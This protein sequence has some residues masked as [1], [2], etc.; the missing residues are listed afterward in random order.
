MKEILKQQFQASYVRE[1]FEK[2]V[3]RPIFQGKVNEY[4][5]LD[6]KTTFSVPLTDGEKTIAKSIN[7]YGHIVTADDR[8]IE[9]Y[10]VVLKDDKVVERNK[11]SIGALVKKQII[12]NN[13]VFINFTYENP[14]DKN[15]RFSFIAF[16]SVFEDGD[17]KTIETNPKRYTYI[18]GESD[19]TYKTAVD[20]FSKL[21]D[22]LE[23]KIGKIKDAFGVEAMSKAFF[24]EY[25]DTHYKNFVNH[26]IHSN[27]KKSAFDGD[28]KAIR[29]FIKK[30]LGRIVFLYF[31]QKK[32][33]LGATTLD[34]NDGDKNFISNFFKEAKQGMDFYSMWLSKL[35][36]DTLNEKRKDDNFTMPDDSVVKIPYLNGGLF[37]K[38]TDK[39]DFITFEPELFAS[40][41][42]F[43]DQYNFTV[44]EDSPD[45]HT[46]AVDPEMLGHIF[47]N[48]LEH[49]PKTGAFYTP[50]QIVQY[51]T[52]E[53][54]IEYLATYLPNKKNEI[55][56]FIK[57]QIV[58]LNDIE[59]KEIDNLIDKVKICD[60]AI[61]SGA[62]P[63][64][65]LQ[66]IFSLKEQIAYKFGFKVWRPALVKENIIQNSIYGVDIEKGAVD[67]ARLR[68]W[69]SLI[70][71][72]D[73]PKALPNLDYKIVIGNSLVSKFEEE[74]IEIDWNIKEGAQNNLFG[75]SLEE[76]KQKLLTEVSEKQ[77]LFFHTESKDKKKLTSEIRIT[78]IKLLSKQLELMIETKG[79]KE[80]RGKILNKKQ[81]E[82]KLE[83]ES[84]KN[85]L[86]DL[87]RL[88]KNTELPFNHFDWKLDFPEIL[89]PI[90]SENEIGFD[91]VIGNPPYIKEYTNKDAF[92]GFRKSD[93]YQGKMD[94]WYGFSCMMIDNLKD[95]GIQSFI[96]QNNWITSAGASKLRFKILTDTEIKSFVDFGNYKVF[97]SAGIQ[98]MI[99]VV[100][101]KKYETPY[102][103]KYSVLL[104]DKI[105]QSK[106]NDFLN[107]NLHNESAQKYIFEVTNDMISDKSFTFNTN[108][109]EVLLNYIFN[110]ANYFFSE[111]D[112]A[113]GIVPNPD[114]VNNRNIEK[115]PLELIKKFDIK[116]NDGVFVVKRDTFKDIPV[117]EKKYIKP[118]FEPREVSRYKFLNDYE[119]EL[120]YIN[121]SNYKN[122][123]PHLMEHLKKYRSIMDDRRENL[124]GRLDYYHLHWSR[125]ENY[126]KS[127][128]KILA[129]RKCAVP[130]FIYTEEPAYVMMSFNI[131]KNDKLNMKFLT[132]LLN[133]NLIAFWLKN[134]GSMQ[135]SNFQ[136]DKAPLLKIPLFIPNDVTKFT[137]LVDYLLYLNNPN[138]EQLISHTDNKR[139]ASHIEDILNAMINELYFEKHMKDNEL[140]VLDYLKPQSIEDLSDSEQ[141]AIVRN[142]YL[143]YQEPQN[144][145]RQA[146]MLVDTR[147]K[148]ILVKINKNSY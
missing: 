80:D 70:V 53:S 56:L 40:L 93:Y 108:D 117:N 83:T 39:T 28:E 146:I 41:F 11:V 139:V 82:A 103:L 46:V 38:D 125:D 99:Y 143:W 31:L 2:N 30:L 110:K 14:E 145:I 6:N 34:Y 58:E 17:I 43:F 100:Q 144:L 118:L 5:I 36:F 71:D 51:M 54:L 49:N 33:W 23:I 138:N 7:K 76:D 147:S 95:N 61:G 141:A 67:I 92:D 22:E 126:F 29:D 131:I 74:I 133:S 45:D 50:K 37:E 85:T 27:F 10:E 122:D 77:K 94:L 73:L 3:L 81:L 148:D 111:K 136:L 65:L 120:I 52:Q 119:S 90:V 104:D 129:V 113:Q 88:E 42:D 137:I 140:D 8:K 75:S 20:C 102:S 96:A 106:L 66:E 127:G 101:K 105:P 98:T 26:L 114:V 132:S 68:F 84:W 44:Y 121:K 60:P 1:A 134:K 112:I 142:F 18:F 59:L 79:F 24:D 57:N 107:F 115:I 55:S 78:K 135:G 21:A 109:D 63:M 47:E 130:T 13:A 128:A 16:D 89:N 35:F 72:E 91:I 124:K 87:K 69:L 12:G 48:L 9:F 62:F 97:Q 4:V 32:G 123:A 25:R 116:V 15:W 64:G 86:V 19:E